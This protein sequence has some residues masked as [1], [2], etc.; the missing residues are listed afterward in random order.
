MKISKTTLVG[1][2]CG[3]CCAV[4]VGLYLVSVQEQAQQAQEETLARYGG[5]QVEVCVAKN[6]IAA[7]EIVESSDIVTKT[8]VADLL[9]EGAVTDSS[10]IVG[11][12]LGSSILKGEVVCTRRTERSDTALN[13]PQGKAAISV[14]ARAVQAVGG[15]VE[16]GMAVDVYATGSVSTSKLVSGALVLAA[17]TTDDAGSSSDA[18]AWITL[19]I[20]P[21]MVQEVV[22]AAQTLDL[23]FV[24][25]SEQDEYAEELPEEEGSGGQGAS[26]AAGAS[27]AESAQDGDSQNATENSPSDDKKAVVL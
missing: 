26:D 15:S 6:D 4:C 25:P 16:P 14:P 20:D 11:Q 17:S 23:Y 1:L 27:Q 7:G 9:P 12:R 21:D 8:W 5:E 19:A 10:Q 2:I 13:V 22:T 18:N 3:A 24:L